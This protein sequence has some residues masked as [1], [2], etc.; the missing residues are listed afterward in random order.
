MFGLS[1]TVIIAG[2]VM[3]LAFVGMLFCA[4]LQ[5]SQP[6]AKMAAVFLLAIVIACG[7]YIMSSTMSSNTEELIQ[8]ELKYAKATSVILGREIASQFA[9]GNV[10]IIANNQYEK[11]KRQLELIE[12]LK[13][14][15][16]GLTKVLAVD[17]LKFKK[18]PNTP[19]DMI[20]M[21]DMMTSKHFDELIA[22]YP[23]AD[24][25]V[26]LIGLPHDVHKMKVWTKD[27]PKVALLFGEIF[28]LK[29]AIEAGKIVAAVSY[30][31]GVKF[32]EEPAPNLPDKAFEKRYLLITPSNVKEIAK[33]YPSIFSR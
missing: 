20:M 18:D 31:P 22:K 27:K 12:G 26:S 8:N 14:G 23:K 13:E 7:L 4:K 15:M 1:F 16:A 5:R 29:K 3:I 25:C 32:S 2:I 9:N 17:T 30:R 11:N 28:P 33:E 21:E 24:V 10:L 6:N 19:D